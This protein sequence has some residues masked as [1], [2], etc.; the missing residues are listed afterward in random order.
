MPIGFKNRTDGNIDVAVHACLASLETQRCLAINT[1]G[2]VC[3]QEAPGNPFPHIVLRGGIQ[4]PNFFSK[5]I[6][7]AT[8][9]LKNAALRPS[10]IVDCSHD[11]SGKQYQEQK[12]VFNTLIEQI[13]HTDSAIRGIMLES[14]LRGSNQSLEG[15]VAPDISVTDPCLDWESTKQLIEQGAS[16]I[17]LCIPCV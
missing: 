7:E 15:T 10:I 14:Y 5:S 6:D 8:V 3:V 2:A 4:G 1:S 9:T 17:A 16:K 13:T 12:M 11:N